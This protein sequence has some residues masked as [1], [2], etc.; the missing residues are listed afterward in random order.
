MGEGRKRKKKVILIV[1]QCFLIQLLV[2]RL[3]EDLRVIK[4][5]Y[6]K[7]LVSNYLFDIFNR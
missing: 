4:M 1:I 3:S 2:F 5:Y 6:F 7:N